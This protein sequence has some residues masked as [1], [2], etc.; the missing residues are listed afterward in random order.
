MGNGEYNEGF[1][2]AMVRK[3]MGPP[4]M[5]ATALA[6]EVGVPQTTLSRWLKDYGRMAAVGGDMSSKK[7]PGKHP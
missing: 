1:K 6:G 7:R 2:D 5:S 3:M 4:S